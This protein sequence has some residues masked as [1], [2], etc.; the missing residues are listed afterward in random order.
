MAA[1]VALR[2]SRQTELTERFPLHVV[3]E[4]LG[5]TTTVATQHYLLVRDSDFEKALE[6]DEVGEQTAAQNP[7]E[8]RLRKRRQGLARSGNTEK[9]KRKKA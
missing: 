7:L 5:N 8:I 1:G 6:R 3:C 9:P 2:A 4:G